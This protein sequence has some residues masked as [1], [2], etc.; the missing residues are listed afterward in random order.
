MKLWAIS[1]LELNFTEN[2]VD[3]VIRNL[4]DSKCPGSDGIDGIIVKR[5]HKCLPKFWIS[6]FDKCLLLGCFLKEWKKARLTA[7]LKSDK[8]KLHSVQ[9]YRGIS[10]LSIPGKLKKR[11]NQQNAQINSGLI[12]LLLFNH[13]NMFRPLNRSHH[14]GVQNP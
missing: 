7:I 11:T 4:D 12:N 14:Q 5:L 6:L 2:E 3:E 13:S 9:G 8:T 10:L 1:R